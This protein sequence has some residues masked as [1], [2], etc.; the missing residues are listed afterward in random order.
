MRFCVTG[1]KIASCYTGKRYD[2]TE[3][4]IM[5]PEQSPTGLLNA[6]QVGYVA[7]NMKEP[8]EGITIPS[9]FKH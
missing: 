9:R 8:S 6:G 5:Y 2:V 3:V 4:G 7:C 1:D